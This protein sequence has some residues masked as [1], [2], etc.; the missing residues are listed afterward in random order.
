MIEK[1]NLWTISACILA[2]LLCGSVLAAPRIQEKGVQAAEEFMPGTTFVDGKI[3]NGKLQLYVETRQIPSGRLEAVKIFAEPSHTFLAA[4]FD[5]NADIEALIDMWAVSDGRPLFKA[6]GDLDKMAPTATIAAP[7]SSDT[8][9]LLEYVLRNGNDELE[10]VEVT[11]VNFYSLDPSFAFSSGFS[12][13][14]RQDLPPATCAWCSGTYCGCIVCR[15]RHVYVCCVPGDRF[16]E[17]TCWP[18]I[19]EILTWQGSTLIHFAPT[20]A[21][22]HH[23]GRRLEVKSRSGF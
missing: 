5:T 22:Q 11:M 15:L 23:V 10:V 19:S 21:S 20:L 2:L 17:M 7:P 16:C 3:D 8:S 14:L 13:N 18:I 6:Q 1:R 4:I 12:P 9:I